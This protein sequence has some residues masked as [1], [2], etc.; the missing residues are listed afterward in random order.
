H[1]RSSLLP[2]IWRIHQTENIPGHPYCLNKKVNGLDGYK[3]TALQKWTRFAWNSSLSMW[4]SPTS[5]TGSAGAGPN[6]HDYSNDT[7]LSWA[8]GNLETI[9]VT[10]LNGQMPITCLVALLA[11]GLRVEQQECLELLCRAA[12]SFEILQGSRLKQ[13]PIC[14]KIWRVV[15]TIVLC[16]I[17]PKHNTLYSGQNVNR[18]ATFL[19]VLF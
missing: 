4:P 3:C 14:L 1:P 17:C 5:W 9:H 7:P 6:A 15:L 13:P 8:E 18:L 11:W 19:A 2:L 12:G 16:C 10:N